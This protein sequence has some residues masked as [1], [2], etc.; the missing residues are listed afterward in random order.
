MTKLLNSFR[1]NN[2]LSALTLIF[3]TTVVAENLKPIDEIVVRADFRP[4]TLQATVGSLTVITEELI[5]ARAGQ[6]IEDILNVAPNVNF[7]SGSSRARFFQIRGIG[8][9]SQFSQP[10]NP[11]VGFMIDEVD[12][13]G[14]G[15]AATLFDVEQVEVLRGPQG[16]RYGANA[17]A[18][19]ISLHTNRPTNETTG[20]IEAT[21]GNYNTYSLG[22]VANTPLVENRLFARIALQRHQSDG[23]IDN[24]FLDRSDTNNRDELTS[25]IKLRWL[26]SD[27]LAVDVSL[28]H[29]DI[30]N[31][32]DAFSLDNNRNTLSDEP[33]DDKQETNAF[34][35]EVNYGL[36]DAANLVSIVAYADSQLEYSYDEDW[37]Y[38]GITGCQPDYSFCEYSSFDQYLRDREN[39]S[40]ELR[41]VSDQAGKIMSNSTDWVLG[42]YYA[43]KDEALQRNYTY[44]D[45]PFSSDYKTQNVAVYGQLDTA[46][47]DRLTL[48]TGLR[49]EQWDA[50]YSDNNDLRID[51]DEALVGGK[52]ALDYLFNESHSFYS[53]LSKGYKAGGVNTDGSLPVGLRDFDTEYL[54]NI[55]AGLKSTSFDNRWSSRISVFY[56]KRKEQQVKGSFVIVRQGQGTEFIDFVDNAA[57][58]DNYG[59]EAD[60]SWQLSEQIQLFGALGLLET[61]VEGYVTPDGVDISG[62]DQAHAPNYQFNLGANYSMTKQWSARI[63]LEGKDAFYFSNRHDEKSLSY[64]L[65][66]ARLSYDQDSWSFALWGRNLTDERYETRG[67]GFAN[68]PRNDYSI[69]GYQQLGEPR[70]VGV[71]VTYSVN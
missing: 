61:K 34:S 65:L 37:S 52:I 4:A 57:K 6:H 8:E 26:A 64:E 20:Y 58:G 3:T 55:E 41:L 40:L 53:S 39:Y 11:S 63:D 42:L 43:D 38:E 12:F 54:W 69:G 31:G 60:F 17:L 21:T 67:F 33:G 71:S 15:T 49:F 7:A 13:S 27:D 68:D 50:D 35:I 30:N 47:N 22:V 19:V 45:G 9:R 44:S 1:L 51:T 36:N 29:F 46:I 70:V 59:L 25:R 24:N 14:I 23:Y 48:I 62:R 5:R 18:G 32:Y 56:T 16:T 2:A 10:I 28:F 66:N